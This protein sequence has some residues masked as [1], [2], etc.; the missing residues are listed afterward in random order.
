MNGAGKTTLLA[1]VTGEHPQS[2]T[3]SSKLTLFSRPRA[4]WPTPHLH[5]RIGRVSPEMHNAFPRRR[6]MTVWDAVGTGFEGNFVPRGRFRVGFGPDG[7][8]LEAG[9]ETERWRVRRMWE[10]L[11]ALGP[12]AWRGAPPSEDEA[13]EAQDFAQRPFAD[14]APG[15]QSVVLLMRALVGR[16]PL[17]LLDEAWAG[18]DEGMVRAARAYL[19]EGGLAD[20]QA[21]VVVSHWEEEV[22]WTREDG[23]Q[24]FRLSDGSGRAE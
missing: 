8:E 24:R 12:A 4:K 6:G 23:V 19:R 20:G 16:P 13:R 9:G 22:P 21:C 3:Q 2:Y 10:V 18:M 11:R 1:M 15:E 5:A 14:L 7:G 17:V